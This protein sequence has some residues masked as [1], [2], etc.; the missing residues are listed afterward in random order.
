MNLYPEVKPQITY[1]VYR[2]THN[3]WGQNNSTF[4]GNLNPNDPVDANLI[5]EVHNIIDHYYEPRY[6]GV[7]DEDRFEYLFHIRLRSIENKF[8]K[9]LMLDTNYPTLKDI[10]NNMA[11]LNNSN[12]TGNISDTDNETRTDN[13]NE[14]ITV[15]EDEHI[16][17][18]ELTNNL[19]DNRTLSY[20]AQS[21]NNTKTLDVYHVINETLGATEQNTNR[22]DNLTSASSGSG[23]TTYGKTETTN[24]TDTQTGKARD[25]VSDTPQSN[26][27]SSTQGLD[28]P[29]TWTYASQ[30]QD[31]SQTNSDTRNTTLTNGGTDSA[32]NS[33]TT[34]NTGT[35]DI[36]STT[37]E[38][39]NISDTT[40]TGTVGDKLDINA[41]SDTD[42]LTKT[43]TSTTTIT[44][45]PH[46]I[47]TAK[48]NTGTQTKTG[49]STRETHDSNEETLEGRNLK[50]S[51]LIKDFEDLC[52]R[53]VSS[54]FYL[55][56]SLDDLF[57]SVWDIDWL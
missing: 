15:N 41:H 23:S 39:N 49:T 55:F 35:Q 56:K 34:T 28:T 50:L 7:Q 42:N 5:N 44:D 21:S 3:P 40:D 57:Y 29:V 10:L 37:K 11:L 31:H 54:Y 30:L 43:G 14:N 27:A 2:E 18:S 6:L 46:Q 9:S 12:G 25:L 8:Y 13:L 52:F 36:K 33:D 24:L 1:K 48:T 16:R 47:T 17:T 32:T 22:T 53:T 38:V 26:V 51:E 19:T 45:D 4:I 20:G